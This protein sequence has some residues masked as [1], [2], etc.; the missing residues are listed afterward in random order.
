MSEEQAP[1]ILHVLEPA[2]A[3]VPAYV[4][5]LGS[6]LSDRGFSQYVLTGLD[7]DWDFTPW[8]KSVHRLQWHRTIRS[9]WDV[10][11]TLR[12]LVATTGVNLVH[13]HASWAGLAARVRRVSVPI[14]YQ[15]HGWGRDSLDGRGER[16]IASAVEEILAP[17]SARLL[18]LSDAEATAAPRV[19]TIARVRPVLDLTSFGP[20]DDVE[21]AI[22]RDRLGWPADRPVALCVGELSARKRQVELVETWREVVDESVELVLVGDGDQGDQLRASLGSATRWLGWRHDVAE[23]MR[24]ADYLVVASRGEGFSL[25]IAEALASGLAVFSTEVGGSEAIGPADGVVAKEIVGLVRAVLDAD[26]RLTEDD[27]RASRS[28]RSISAYG[29]ESAVDEVSEIYDSMF[30]T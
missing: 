18:L 14:A 2:R 11:S 28:T 4:D 16:L 1:S 23:L 19:G 3:G 13:A 5:R 7:Q 17:R 30:A 27:A 12:E 24:A 25:V 29:L 20:V 10:S 6:T 21:R 8:A 26:P 15:P 9:T 22:L